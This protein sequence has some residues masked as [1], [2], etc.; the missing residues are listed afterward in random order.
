M[1]RRFIALIVSLAIAITAISA[2]PARADDTAKVLGGLA[3]LTILGVVLHR[4]NKKKKRDR[5]KVTQSYVPQAPQIHSVRPLPPKVAKYDL[6]RRCLKPVRGYPA[7]AP[8][9]KRKCLKRH[10]HHAKS[11]PQQC[12]ITYWNGERTRNA[13]EPRCLRRKGYRIAG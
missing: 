12:Q 8:L 2:A 6:P 13:Y 10:Y 11:L 1:H 7:N 3:A 5:A 4:N 9:M